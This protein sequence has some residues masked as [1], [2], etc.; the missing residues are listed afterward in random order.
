L[1]DRKDQK[2]SLKVIEP[3]RAFED[4]LSLPVGFDSLGK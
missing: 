3:M 2:L 1:E 4:R